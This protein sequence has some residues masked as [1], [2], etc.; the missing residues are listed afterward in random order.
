MFC[1][2]TSKHKALEPVLKRRNHLGDLC[3]ASVHISIN[4]F[5]RLAVMV[6]AQRRGKLLCAESFLS[7]FFEHASLMCWFKIFLMA[8]VH[9]HTVMTAVKASLR[10]QAWTNMRWAWGVSEANSPGVYS[11]GFCWDAPPTFCVN[12]CSIFD[13]KNMNTTWTVSTIRQQLCVWRSEWW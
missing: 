12:I 4:H 7:V 13:S 6:K 3:S 10:P 8:K 11:D 5:G 1:C 9:L 2:A